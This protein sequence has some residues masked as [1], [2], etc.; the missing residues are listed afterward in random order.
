MLQQATRLA[1]LDKLNLLAFVRLW[2]L[3]NLRPEDFEGRN[4]DDGKI[5][6]SLAEMAIQ[7]ASKD[8]DKGGRDDE[9]RYILP[10]AEKAM[11]RF[12]ENI[13]LKFNVAKLLRDLNRLEEARTLA[14]E[15]ARSKAGEYWSWELLGDLEAER[16]MRLSCYAKALTC[17]ED[18]NRRA[19]LTPYRRP[20]LTPLAA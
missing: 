11:K 7:R 2:Q 13:W 10:F 17:S 20:K 14:V 3:E 8:A 16:A 4:A 6:P 12:P 15:F 5:F 18:V 19:N 1:Q 9:M